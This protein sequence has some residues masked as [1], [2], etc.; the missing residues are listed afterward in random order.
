ML[1]AKARYTCPSPQ[2]NRKENKEKYLFYQEKTRHR[3]FVKDNNYL[4]F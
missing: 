2:V 3:G 1:L 4:R